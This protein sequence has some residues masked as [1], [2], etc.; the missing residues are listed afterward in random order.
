MHIKVQ[1]EHARITSQKELHTTYP[2]Q[3]VLSVKQ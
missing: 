3:L 2:Q 1:N